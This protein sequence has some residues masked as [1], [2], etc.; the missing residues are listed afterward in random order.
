VRTYKKCAACNVVRYCGAECQR[1][2]WKAAHK[3][4]C[5]RLKVEA[6]AEER[7]VIASMMERKATQAATC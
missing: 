2:H 6:E 4:E 5:A 1:V 7:G 3:D